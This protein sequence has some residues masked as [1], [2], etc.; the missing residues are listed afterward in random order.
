MSLVACQLA[1]KETKKKKKEKKSDDT[2]LSADNRR[3]SAV[4]LSRHT[5]TR[6]F[7]LEENEKTKTKKRKA[8]NQSNPNK[9]VLFSNDVPFSCPFSCLFL[10]SCW[11]E[12]ISFTCNLFLLESYILNLKMKEEYEGKGQRPQEQEQEQEKELLV[13]PASAVTFIQ[14]ETRFGVVNV[15]VQGCCHGEL[16][17]I[18]AKVR[19]AEASTGTKVDLLLI[20]GDFEC[21][22]DAVDLCC[23]AVPPKYRHLKNFHK[24]FSGECTAPVKTIFIGGN[25][26]ASNVL[27]SLYYGGYVAP[28]IY[29]LGWAAVVNYKGLRIGGLSGIYN[30]KHYTQG[31]YHQLSSLH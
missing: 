21:V 28:N 20:C 31:T 22:R 4:T 8:K 19:E 10:F 27:Q 11:K 29:F 18:Y 24:Y 3:Q 14:E 1:Q 23:M 25:H 2:D 15:A 9:A 17:T 5:E 12:E 6:L 13:Q 30:D 7:S 16:D 26:E